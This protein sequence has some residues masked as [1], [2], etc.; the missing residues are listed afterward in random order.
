MR[1]KHGIYREYRRLQK[2]VARRY[3]CE[4]FVKLTPRDDIKGISYRR[5]ANQRRRL[6][7]RLCVEYMKLMVK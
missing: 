2:I 6:S 3:N 7:V 5:R 1:V 4:A